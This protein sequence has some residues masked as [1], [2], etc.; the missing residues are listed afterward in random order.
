MKNFDEN[1][2]EDN[3]DLVNDMLELNLGED[4]I[5]QM[6]IP[7]FIPRELLFGNG[8]KQDERSTTPGPCECGFRHWVDGVEYDFVIR[9]QSE[10]GLLPLGFNVDDNPYLIAQD[11]VSRHDLNK[12]SLN[13][14]PIVNKIANAIM[15]STPERVRGKTKVKSKEE[16]EKSEFDPFQ[17]RLTIPGSRTRYNKTTGEF[18]HTTYLNI[19]KKEKEERELKERE[20]L[21]QENKIQV[22]LEKEKEEMERDKIK[23]R[24]RMDKMEVEENRKRTRELKSNLKTNSNSFS[25]KRVLLEKMANSYG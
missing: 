4:E 3:G 10:K 18:S 12:G 5:Q 1:N 7:S 8:N 20:K 17:A 21:S 6:N 11:F 15:E 2:E 22:Q 16:E 24:M 14:Q 25:K 9:L 13:D 19:E 23:N